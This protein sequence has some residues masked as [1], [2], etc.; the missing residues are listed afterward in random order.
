MTYLEIKKC[1]V[2]SPERVHSSLL[3]F[4]TVAI[5]KKKKKIL[6]TASLHVPQVLWRAFIMIKADKRENHQP[7]K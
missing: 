6:Q 5:S 1:L 4:L 3:S 2:V 7:K